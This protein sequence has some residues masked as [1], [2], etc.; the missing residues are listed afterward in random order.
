[1]IDFFFGVRTG[2]ADWRCLRDN[3]VVEHEA[4]DLVGYRV[5][6]R[7]AVSFGRCGEVERVTVHTW[8]DG[9]AGELRS[10]GASWEARREMVLVKLT[11]GRA[12]VVLQDDEC[13]IQGGILIPDGDAAVRLALSS[14]AETV[15]HAGSEHVIFV[16]V[17]KG[18]IV[19]VLAPSNA[20]EL[21]ADM[22]VN[23]LL[24]MRGGHG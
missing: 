11:E 4:T 20:R 16:S 21:S 10:V 8:E 18:S 22:A 19:D 5:T 24:A 14:D 15:A 12:M 3:E 17:H 23:V 7:A 13:R 2:R 9:Y 6:S 1:M